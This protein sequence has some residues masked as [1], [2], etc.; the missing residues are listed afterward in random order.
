MTGL[1]VFYYQNDDDDGDDN[2][3]YYYHQAKSLFFQRNRFHLQLPIS[4]QRGLSS[5]CR[6]LRSRTLLKPFDGFRCQLAGRLKGFS[7]T[8]CQMGF[9]TPRERGDLGLNPKPKYANV[10]CG[11]T[12][13][14]MLP[15][16]ENRRSWVDLPQRFRLLSNYFG[17]CYYYCTYVMAQFHILSNVK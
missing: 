7:D 1:S 2:D 5:V 14:P 8:L 10:N 15:P 4:P 3:Y 16:G 9:L 17:F 12:V 6:L 13:S 11:Q